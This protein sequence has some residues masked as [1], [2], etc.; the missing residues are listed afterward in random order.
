MEG[1]GGQ[2]VPPLAKDLLQKIHIYWERKSWLIL[3]VWPLN[4]SP[5]FSE[6]PHTQEYMGSLKLTLD[7]FFKTEWKEEVAVDQGGVRGCVWRD[8]DENALFENFQAL[9]KTYVSFFFF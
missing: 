6:W 2:E 8:Y 3:R 7:S 5:C 1:K 9:I 4:G